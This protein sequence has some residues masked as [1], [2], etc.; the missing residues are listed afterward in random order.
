[1]LFSL[2]CWNESGE[3]AGS[4][5]QAEDAEQDEGRA[6][7]PPQHAAIVARAAA[8][9]RARS[10]WPISRFVGGSRTR[11]RAPA[12]QPPSDRPDLPRLVDQRLLG[13]ARQLL[14][15]VLEPQ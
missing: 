14:D 15:R 2:P 9:A 1:M 7:E 4:T 3:L 5:E 8:R 13:G 12:A 6:C 11:S 10:T